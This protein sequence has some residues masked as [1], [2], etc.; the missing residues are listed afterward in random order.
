MSPNFPDLVSAIELFEILLRHTIR[1][2]NQAEELG[3][4]LSVFVRERVEEI[5]D[6]TLAILRPVGRDGSHG[7]KFTYL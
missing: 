2:L 6:G 1:I 4:P 3:Y 5:L 7:M